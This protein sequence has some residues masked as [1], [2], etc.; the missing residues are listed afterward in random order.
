MAG[1]GSPASLRPL[2]LSGVG[3]LYFIAFYS[4]YLQFPG[5]FGTDGITP[6]QPYMA[7]LAQHHGVVEADAATWDGAM[8]L[9]TASPSLLWVAQPLDIA[10]DAWL[11]GLALFG[12]FLSLAT[13]LGLQHVGTCHH[14]PF[15][16][17]LYG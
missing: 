17:Y 11:E 10:L 14:L 15:A 6:A 5:L 8:R 7:R 3:A 9:A 1:G 16:V 12:C 4:Y 2:F 13:V